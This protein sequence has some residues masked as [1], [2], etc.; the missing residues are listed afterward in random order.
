[1][2]SISCFL[3]WILACHVQA[4]TLQLG[5]VDLDG[6]LTPAQMERLIRRALVSRAWKLTSIDGQTIYATLYNGH[7]QADIK[8]TYKSRS[9][10]MD[11]IDSR[12]L[13]YKVKNGVTHIKGKYN[14]WIR[15]LEK[16]L[17]V[18]FEILFSGELSQDGKPETRQDVEEREQ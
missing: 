14:R 7:A 4:N 10:Q 17:P 6:E 11:Y 5:L 3:I 1:M 13:G 16:D 9:I 8:I 18:F 2:K 15:N 12:N